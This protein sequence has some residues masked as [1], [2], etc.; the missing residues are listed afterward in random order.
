MK[1]KIKSYGLIIVLAIIFY[2]M[3]STP[4]S[5][6]LGDIVLEL[7]GLKAWTDGYNGMHLTVI[8]FGIIFFIVY[9]L[10]KRITIDESNKKIK[11]KLLLF[12]C[13]VTIL[14]LSH[15][16]IVHMMMQN[17]DG[18]SSIAIT[19]SGNSY[20]YTIVNGELEEFE[21][22]FSLTNYSRE[23][24]HFSVAGYIN[25]IT[26]FEIYN[27]QGEL[28]KFYLHS[29]GSSIYKINNDNFEIKVNSIDMQQYSGGSGIIDSLILIDDNGNSTKI[30]K[31]RDRGIDK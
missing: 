23:A 18:L 21:C 4:H 12:I 17:A 6:A 28:A 27:K 20:Q 14:Y 15:S 2:L 26:K 1:K 5:R 11:H 22:E 16:A 13:S 19:S 31:L 25:N 8:Y 7:I 10:Y 24:K 3:L 9:M 29:K 30:K